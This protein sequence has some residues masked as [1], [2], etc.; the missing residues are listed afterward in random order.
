V[1]CSR[2]LIVRVALVLRNLA[3]DPLRTARE[4]IVLY[5]PAPLVNHPPWRCRS[6]HSQWINR[7][8]PPWWVMGSPQIG[9]DGGGLGS[10][11][12]AHFMCSSPLV[13]RSHQ[14]PD[15]A[16]RPDS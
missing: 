2:A 6:F 15:L 13:S 10:M 3:V 14:Q 5:V 8:E 16:L 12:L 9:H 4:T 7:T 1:P 11:S